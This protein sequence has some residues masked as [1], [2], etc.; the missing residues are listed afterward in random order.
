MEAKI[1]AINQYWEDVACEERTQITV[2]FT[3]VKEELHLGKC[4]I[5]Q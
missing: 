2:D 5:T 3:E 1:V 4:Q